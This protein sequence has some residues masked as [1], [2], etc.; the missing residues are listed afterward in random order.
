VQMHE[1][2]LYR[3][4]FRWRRN[5]IRERDVIQPALDETTDSCLCCLSR[6]RTSSDDFDD[7]CDI[8][9]VEK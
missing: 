4:L 9:V 7:W 8:G 2:K 1:L 3:L 6:S 5:F